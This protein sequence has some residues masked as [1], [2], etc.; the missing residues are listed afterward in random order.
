M[1]P[2]LVAGAH[3]TAPA[4]PAFLALAGTVVYLWWRGLI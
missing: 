2:E 3:A 4:V 1:S